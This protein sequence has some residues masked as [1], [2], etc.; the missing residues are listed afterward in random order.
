MYTEPIH[1]KTGDFEGPLDLLLS[2]IE[3]RKLYISDVSLAEVADEFIRH[4]EGECVGEA[5]GHDEEMRR[6]YPLAKTAHFIFI[7]STLLLIK[8]KSLLPTLEL[9][10]EEEE[11]VS[12]LERRLKLYQIYRDVARIFKEHARE[13]QTYKRGERRAIEEPVFA[14]HKRIT[15]DT[16][17]SSMR[18]L[19]I[20]LPQEKDTKPQVR[21]GSVMRLEEMIE[22]L[23]ERITRH[24]QTSFKEFSGHGK[25]EKVHVVVSFLAVLEL[26]KRGM[27]SVRQEQLF[28]DIALESREIRTPHYQ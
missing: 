23:A 24:I 7:A 27:L 1:I 26:V 16:L 3:K 6:P 8:S 2:L 14:P 5:S 18:T 21:V 17:L 4:I 9:T 10:S 22:R 28:D 25:A 12:D 20:A 11:S 13:F 19:L 15:Q